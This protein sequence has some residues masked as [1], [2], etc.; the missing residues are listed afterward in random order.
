MDPGARADTRSP[1]EAPTQAP[2]GEVPRRQIS[3][4]A[5]WR[6]RIS[7]KDPSRSEDGLKRELQDARIVRRGNPAELR[8]GCVGGW[9]PEIYVV[10]Y[11]KEFGSKLD[12]EALRDTGVLDHA[13]ISIEESRSSQVVPSRTPKSSDSIGRQFRRVEKPGD[14]VSVRPVRTEVGCASE[15]IRAVRPTPEK[16]LSRP[17]EIVIAKPLCQTTIELSAQPFSSLP[18]KPRAFT[19]G[20]SQTLENLK[21]CGR[22]VPDTP[23]SKLRLN[24]LVQPKSSMAFDHV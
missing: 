22:S 3:P 13:Q 14:H 19:F 21:L 16:E 18:A 9:L 6:K 1:G 12:G 11:V 15:E 20:I 7:K 2:A 10:E 4:G 23:R 8:R 24:G 5:S 17:L